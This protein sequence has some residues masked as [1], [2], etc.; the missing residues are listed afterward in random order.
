[1]QFHQK[2][3]AAI[4]TFLKAWMPEKHDFTGLLM[5]DECEPFYFDVDAA[6]LQNCFMELE[7]KGFA[8]S[9]KAIFQGNHFYRSDTGKCPRCWR[10]RPELHWNNENIPECEVAICDRCHEAIKEAPK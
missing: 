5:L 8:E 9:V 10:F 4:Q 1:M 2:D 6:E 3:A 7:K